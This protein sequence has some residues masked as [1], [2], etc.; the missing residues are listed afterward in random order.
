VAKFSPQSEIFQL[1]NKIKMCFRHVLETLYLN[2]NLE[3]DTINKK[4]G[5]EKG[6]RKEVKVASE[7]HLLDC[8]RN[9]F[10]VSR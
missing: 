1:S 5:K 4:V 7:E 2:T 9:V 10:I 6:I 8:N 3:R